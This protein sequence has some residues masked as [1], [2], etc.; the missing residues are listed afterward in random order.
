MM[1]VIMAY[2]PVLICP[3]VECKI[4]IG[5]PAEYNISREGWLR[6]QSRFIEKFGTFLLRADLEL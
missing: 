2:L 6:W 5:M 1:R 4:L 3:K